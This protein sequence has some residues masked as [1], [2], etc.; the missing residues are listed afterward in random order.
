MRL[1]RKKRIR[2]SP[3]MKEELEK[4]RKAFK[5]EEELKEA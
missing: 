4:V 5:E 3:R 2:K 1:Q